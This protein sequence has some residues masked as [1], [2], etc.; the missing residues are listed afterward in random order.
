MFEVVL[1]LHR[2]SNRFKRKV[3]EVILIKQ[4]LDIALYKR[5]K[6]CQCHVYRY[7]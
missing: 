2:E 6:I 5:L 1:I 4:N 3:L 7:V